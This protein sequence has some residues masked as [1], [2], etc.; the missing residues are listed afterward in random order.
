[1]VGDPL[2]HVSQKNL[3]KSMSQSKNSQ[4]TEPEQELE[5]PPN[6]ALDAFI[7]TIKTVLIAAGVFGIAWILVSI[8]FN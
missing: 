2:L 6:Y 7:F 5:A 8:K 1:M 3:P 4:T